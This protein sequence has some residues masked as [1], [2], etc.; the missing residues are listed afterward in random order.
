MYSRRS[1]IVGGATLVAGCAAATPPVGGGAGG[2]PSR[3]VTVDRLHFRRD[4]RPYRYAGANLWYGAWLGADTAYGNRARL[5]RELDRLQALG[6][7]NLR[8]IGSAEESPLN[9]SITPGFRGPGS[10]YNEDLLKGLDW[11]LA[12]MAKRDMTAVV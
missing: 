1:I 7:R 2:P 12:E 6:I 8:I 11:T 5:A 10:V 9:N 4:G 3:F